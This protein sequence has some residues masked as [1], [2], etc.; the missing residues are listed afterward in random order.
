MSGKPAVKSLGV[1]GTL[2]GTFGSVLIILETVGF[3]VP[4]P[5]TTSIIAAATLASSLLGLFGRVKA[6]EKIDS[7]FF[8]K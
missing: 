8:S 7:I 6:K 4:E 3:I 1:W 2:G 5:V